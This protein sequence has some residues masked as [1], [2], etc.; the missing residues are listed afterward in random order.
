MAGYEKTTNF[1]TSFFIYIMIS[2]I[3]VAG[4]FKIINYS[5]QFKFYSDYMLKWESALMQLASKDLPFPDFTGNNHV[6]YMDNLVT[7]MKNQAIAIPESNTGRPY[8]YK[9]PGR[10]FQKDHTVFLLCFEKQI[11][12]FGLS[13]AMFNMLD[14]KI[15]G[16]LG[17]KSGSFKGREQKKHAEYTGIWDI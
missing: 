4:S 2:V 10:Q 6:K 5:K 14:K 8:I 12:L 9:L 15:D 11:V 13:K 17:A 7:G 16:K 3:V 1:L